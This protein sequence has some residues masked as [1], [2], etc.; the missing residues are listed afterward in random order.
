AHA[1]FYAALTARLTAA[2]IAPPLLLAGLVLVAGVL[3]AG[4]VNDIVCLA[5]VPIG[6]A[7]CSARRLAPRP[8]RLALPAAA[9]IG[10]AATLI[11]NPQNILIGQV[12][13]LSF[14][15]YLGVAAVPALLGLGVVWAVIAAQHAGRWERPAPA[16]PVVVPPF[17]PVQS[18]K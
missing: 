8:F 5:M 12:L 7:G 2:A 3:S 9:N 1:G 17:D 6:V 13:G 18:A 4:L 16:V 15:G 11:G 10:S 14:A